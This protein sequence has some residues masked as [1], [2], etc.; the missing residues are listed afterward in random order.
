MEEALAAPGQWD[1]AVAHF[2]GVDHC[3]H[4][5]AVDHASM[6]AKL[7][8]TDEVVEAAAAKLAQGQHG[9]ALLIVMG[10][11]GQT[12]TGDHGGQ[13]PEET[14]SVL[15]AAVFGDEGQEEEEGVVA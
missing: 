6:H 11:H 10:D 5:Y 4:T 3:G 7:R 1:V 8:W 2:L 13:T 12:M 15:V 9:R 14:N